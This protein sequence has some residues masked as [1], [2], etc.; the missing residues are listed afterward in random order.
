MWQ[1]IKISDWIRK[2]TKKKTVFYFVCSAR[3]VT[4][5]ARDSQL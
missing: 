3:M 5:P 2:K 4:F 1:S